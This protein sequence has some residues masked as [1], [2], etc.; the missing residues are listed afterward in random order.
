MIPSKELQNSKLVEI[1]YN[2]ESRERLDALREKREGQAFGLMLEEVD[3]V[4]SILPFKSSSKDEIRGFVDALHDKYEGILEIFEKEFTLDIGEAYEEVVEIVNKFTGT[5]S[6]VPKLLIGSEQS[7][8]YKELKKVKKILRMGF[9][10]SLIAGSAA[11]Y[12]IL[13]V[14]TLTGVWLGFNVAGY[15]TGE[16]MV[17]KWNKKLEDYHTL[18]AGFYRPKMIEEGYEEVIYLSDHTQQYNIPGLLSHEYAHHLTGSQ[19][20]PKGNISLFEEGFSTGIELLCEREFA[21]RHD[22]Q[23]LQYISIDKEWRGLN[24]VKELLES[25]ALHPES[26]SID[27]TIE[28]NKYDLGGTLFKI[29]EHKYGPGIYSEILKG[30]NVFT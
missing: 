29:L 20:K 16:Y 4:S 24:T 9:A 30:K 1:L 26:A 8:L 11:T 10:T 12:G 7:P 22:L 27:S 23:H 15:A 25:D 3:K 28:N 21:R 17:H 19:V 18:F 13:Q 5:K 14:P 2:E 6:N